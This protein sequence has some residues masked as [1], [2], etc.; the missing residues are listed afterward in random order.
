MIIRLN[1]KQKKIDVKKLREFWQKN[2]KAKQIRI[3]HVGKRQVLASYMADQ[4]EKKKI[5]GEFAWQS[6]IT[7][8]SW[9]KGWIPKGF[10]KEFGRL[11]VQWIDAPEPIRQK[12]IRDTIIIRSKGV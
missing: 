3:E 10:T 6:I 1:Y 4:R 2:H 12:V 5:G 11:W 9:S 8:W 7:R